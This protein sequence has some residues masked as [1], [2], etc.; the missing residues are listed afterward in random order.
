MN[1]YQRVESYED[2]TYRQRARMISLLE[3]IKVALWVIVALLTFPLV[4]ELFV[5]LPAM[6]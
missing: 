2:V 5:I 3:G 4:I 1:P 6:R